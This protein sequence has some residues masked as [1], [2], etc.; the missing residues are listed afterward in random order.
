VE[1]FRQDGR[2][3]D[4]GRL[5]I[6]LPNDGNPRFAEGVSGLDISWNEL[7]IRLRRAGVNLD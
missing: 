7:L 6:S 3:T 2:E 5:E 1:R 4:Y